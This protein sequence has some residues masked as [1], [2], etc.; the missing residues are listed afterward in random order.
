MN[1]KYIVTVGGV[2]VAITFG[3]AILISA[4]STSPFSQ[5]N[6]STVAAID[7]QARTVT[8]SYLQ[9]LS[10]APCYLNS[11][12][13]QGRKP[14]MVKEVEVLITNAFDQV[15]SD[16][17]QMKVGDIVTVYFK[18]EGGVQ[19]P[20]AL[21]DGSLVPPGC[22]PI[23]KTCSGGR[24]A[25]PTIRTHFT[26][27]GDY[28]KDGN[29]DAAEIQKTMDFSLQKLAPTADELSI[30]DVTGDGKVG[31]IDIVNIQDN[32]FKK[33]PAS[34]VAV[35]GGNVMLAGDFNKDTKVV[36]SEVQMILDSILQKI[37][38]SPSEKA[39]AD[40]NGDGKVDILDS[41]FAIDNSLDKKPLKCVEA[42]SV[43]L[44]T[45]IT[46]NLQLGAQGED[47]VVLQTTLQA[48]GYF[49]VSITPTGYFGS[50][51]K[52]AVIDYQK[53]S[54]LPTTG[55]VGPLT[56]EALSK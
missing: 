13:G 42:V 6:L 49:P 53:A 24:I 21:K 16:I 35:F 2:V 43:P 52:N 39:I 29:V 26:K 33:K 23:T 9:P 11:C 28:N 19:R 38:L 41:G 15:V 17:A 45:P 25:T 56:R 46:K 37:T 36:Q 5:A 4:Q 40:A 1:K 7:L 31:A 27:G 20:Y 54:G 8:V 34:C 55:Y 47:V 12:P 3:V 44:I 32:Q 18:T 30:G 10:A 48:A 14:D 51:T 22:D 50:V